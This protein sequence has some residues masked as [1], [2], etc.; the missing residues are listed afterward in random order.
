MGLVLDTNLGESRY[1]R[2]SPELRAGGHREV[3]G[4][5]GW[6]LT[7]NSDRCLISGFQPQDHC[8]ACPWHPIQLFA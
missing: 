5:H 6:S 8:H 7:H 3:R 2:K 4:P 1:R